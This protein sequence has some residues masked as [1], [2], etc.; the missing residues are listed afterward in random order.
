MPFRLRW[1]MPSRG[2][3]SRRS[4]RSTRSHASPDV[5]DADP[6]DEAHKSVDH[7]LGP[8]GNVVVWHGEEG[9]VVVD[10]FVQGSYPALKQRLDALSTAPVV[11]T[12]NTHWHFDH[13]DNNESFRT[14][15]SKIVAHDN[16]KRRLSESHDLLGMH[17]TPAPAGAMPTDTFA[18]SHQIAF[19]LT[20]SEE[21]IDLA[22]VP[23]AHTDTDV[24]VY[25]SI[26]TCCTWAIRSSTDNTR[27]LTP[28]PAAASTA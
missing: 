15:G 7:A 14:A 21:Y 20:G 5:G 28:P 12:V 26:G 11:Y 18:Q 24:A 9:K 16:T 13:A 6:G 27:S 8:G 19:E 2:R 1:L 25:F 10:T 3:R 17:F 4:A 23:P 22:Y